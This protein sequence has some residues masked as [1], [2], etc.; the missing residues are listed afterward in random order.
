MSTLASSSALSAGSDCQTRRPSAP[1]ASSRCQKRRA[2]SQ[3]SLSCTAVTPREA[4]SL[5]ARAHRLDVL[6]VGGLDVAVAELPAR[7]LT[8]D[9]RRL[10]VLVS[11]DH[12]AGHLQIAV[13]EGERG[14]V[15]PDRMRVA[16][17]QRDRPVG[18]DR[19]QRALGRVDRRRPFAAP[20]APAAEP[21]RPR[22]AFERVAARARAPLPAS[23]CPRAAPRPAPSPRWGSARGSR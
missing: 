14:R 13:G 18:D 11:L 23:S 16:G 1:S 19:V 8:Q 22:R 6:V 20:P 12:A 15:E 7:L 9:A 10:A 17:H 4:A 5:H 2:P 3:P 21:G